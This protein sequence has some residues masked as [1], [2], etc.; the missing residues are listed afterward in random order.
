MVVDISG[1]FAAGNGFEPLSP[2]RL[3]DTRGAATVDGINEVTHRIPVGG[4]VIRIP[5]VG[6]AGVPLTGVSA[7]ALNVTVVDP[8]GSAHLTVFP[9][10]ESVPNAANLNFVTGQTVPNMVIAKLGA[11]GSVSIYSP[12]PSVHVVVDISG[13]FV[14]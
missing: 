1:W 9:T 11:D 14:G 3:A 5:V 2:A 10:G 4:G 12:G 7:V 13:W 8:L 6:R